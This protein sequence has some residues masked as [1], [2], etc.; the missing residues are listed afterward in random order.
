MAVLSTTGVTKRFGGLVAVN[1]VNCEI[2]RNEIVGII[3]PNGAGKSTLF[4][5]ITG[6]YEP[7][8]GR[9]MFHDKDIT[10]LKPNEIT[11][12]GIARTFQNIR[13][14]KE[15]TVIE[16]VMVGTHTRTKTNLIDAIFKLPRY[17][18]AE[19]QAHEK[20]LSML[21][22]VGLSD[23]QYH[24]ATSLP[25]GLQRRLEIARAIAS[26]PEVLLFD[27]PAAGMNEHETS[28]LMDLIRQ[29]KQMGYTI[30]LIE[31]DMKLVMNIC[32]RIYVL[33]HGSLIASGVPSE[34]KSNPLVIEAYLGK[35]G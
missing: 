7:T 3:G 34:I 18:Q 24:Y 9:V 12:L 20:A 14:F 17:R 31:H 15:M 27:E 35:A 2:N 22:L 28:D 19:K 26:D 11:S 6:V 1:S 5:C 8:E 33:D 10:G 13:L 25:Y 16:N 29:L 23:Y 21:E 4:N 32:E 30:L